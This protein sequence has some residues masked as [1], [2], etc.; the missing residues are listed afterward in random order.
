MVSCVFNK[1]NPYN[2]QAYLI[3]NLLMNQIKEQKAAN[4]KL[5]QF[6]LY[7]KRAYRVLRITL[8]ALFAYNRVGVESDI[9]HY[10]SVV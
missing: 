6:L 4:R 2:K 1:K 8:H 9:N 3:I 5:T 10:T 7:K